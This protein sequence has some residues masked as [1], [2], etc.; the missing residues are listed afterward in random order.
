MGASSV[1]SNG[2]AY[3]H[4][5][6]MS[7]FTE[8][9]TLEVDTVGGASGGKRVTGCKLSNLTIEFNGAEGALAYTV[10]GQGKIATKVTA[11]NPARTDNSPWQGWLGTVTCSGYAAKIVTGSLTLE[12]PLSGYHTMNNTQDRLGTSTGTL[13]V[14]GR[15]TCIFE[16]MVMWD[17]FKSHLNQSFVIAFSAGSGATEKT[18]T[19]TATSMGLADGAF[20][21]DRSSEGLLV[22]IPIRALYNTTDQ[23]PLAITLVNARS[24]YAA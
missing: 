22:N 9:L 8:S 24:S 10:Q 14:S 23:G 18:L 11:T 17:N 5:F 21:L 15:L 3:V 13:A 1:Y 7:R 20:E 4:E 19:F 12:R 16:N 2:S 6:Y